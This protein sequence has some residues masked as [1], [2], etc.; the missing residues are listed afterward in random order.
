MDLICSLIVMFA[1]FQAQFYDFIFNSKSFL[2]MKYK[3]NTILSK[4]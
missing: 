3:I 1:W 2:S 4:L